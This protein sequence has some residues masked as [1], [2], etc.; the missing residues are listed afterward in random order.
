[1]VYLNSRKEYSYQ[2][3]S[4][5]I[6]FNLRPPQECKQHFHCMQ[7][8]NIDDGSKIILLVKS[9]HHQLFPNIKFLFLKK[10][11]FS[12]FLQI[13]MS[14]CPFSWDFALFKF[15][16]LEKFPM[17]FL[18]RVPYSQRFIHWIYF[19]CFF[20][21]EILILKY[22]RKNYKYYTNVT[23]TRGCFLQYYVA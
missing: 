5:N 9:H 4:K 19:S 16:Y 6:L 18:P 10:H 23:K 12:Y 13:K 14:I 7:F 1:M 11:C 21:Y 8:L 2:R 20:F 22:S 15:S 3:K 17:C